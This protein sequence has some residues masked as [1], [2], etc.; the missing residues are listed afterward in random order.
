MAP[1]FQIAH[2][3][4]ELL[5][6]SQMDFVHAHLPQRRLAAALPS[7]QIAQ[8]DRPH[9]ARR[10]PKR[11]ATRRAAALSQACPTASSKRLL[12]GALLGNCGTFSIY[13]AVRALTRY[14]STTTV[15]RYSKHGR[16]RT[17]RSTA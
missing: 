1:G 2:Y 7:F 9:R 5:L 10:Q 8:I 16:S 3:R 13:A 11:R 14:T 6:L 15:V 12:N 4:Q 17:S